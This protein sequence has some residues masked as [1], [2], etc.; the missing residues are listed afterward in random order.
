M[1]LQPVRPTV[2]WAASKD[3][4]QQGE[5]GDY[6]LLL[7]ICWAHLE[8]CMLPGYRED[9]ELLEQVQRRATKIR[10]LEFLSYEEKLRELG[11]FNLDK[12]KFQGGF[13]AA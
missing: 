2:S 10:G 8:Y 7:C 6:P 3:G 13:I 5:G 1:L 11:L 12:R 9:G 4:S